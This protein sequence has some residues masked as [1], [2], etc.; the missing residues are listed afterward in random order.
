MKKV[1]VVEDSLEVRGLLSDMLSLNDFHVIEARN[2]LEAIEV[3]QQQLP[4]LILC[5]IH[6]PE[7][8]GFGTLT[9]LRNMPG[10][11][12]IPFIFLTGL[13]EKP[14]LPQDTDLG[15]DDYLTKPFTFQELLAAVRAGLEKKAALAQD[16]ERK[17]E[18][19]IVVT[20]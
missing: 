12:A 5:D 1:L 8:Y 18:E 15:A 11:A 14:S 16:A 4:D 10:T 3:A 20:A 2:G 17:F 13:S 7:L 6:M 19:R 9:R